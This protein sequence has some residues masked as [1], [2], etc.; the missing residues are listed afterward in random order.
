MN[1]VESIQFKGEKIDTGSTCTY[2]GLTTLGQTPILNWTVTC[3]TYDAEGD[4]I[5]YRFN[6]SHPLAESYGPGKTSIFSGNGKYKG[7][8][9]SATMSCKRTVKNITDPMRWGHT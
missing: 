7:I 8:S 5:F 6:G 4:S 9:G 1:Y 2:L 3:Q